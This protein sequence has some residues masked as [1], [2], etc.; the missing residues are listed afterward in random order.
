MSG[1]PTTSVEL[2]AAGQVVVVKRRCDA[3]GEDTRREAQ[4]LEA[5]RHPGVV[6]LA[7]SV[8][9]SGKPAVVTRWVGPH[10]LT[11]IGAMPLSQA[12]AIMAALADSVADLHD[13][14]VVHGS[15]TS[16]HVLVSADGRPVL[17]GFGRAHLLS[18]E[19]EAASG[20]GGTPTAEDD[21]AA[22]GDLLRELVGEE[23]DLEPIPDRRGWRRRP[24][25]HGYQRRALLTLADQAS[26]D[27]RRLRPTARALAAA[28]HE[29]IPEA[30][31]GPVQGAPEIPTGVL[32]AG[33]SAYA[34]PGVSPSAVAPA[35]ES[36]AAGSRH[37]GVK[38]P[39]PLSIFDHPEA[40]P[41]PLVAPEG[42]EAAPPLTEGRSVR[43][44]PLLPNGLPRPGNAQSRARAVPVMA[45]LVGVA[46]LLFGINELLSPPGRRTA[47]RSPTTRG[48]A[49]SPA[50]LRARIAPPGSSPRPPRPRPVRTS[51]H[52]RPSHPC[53]PVPPSS[54]D[55]DGDGCP[56]PVRVSGTLVQVR[57]TRYGVGRPGDRVLVG[58]WDC[59]RQATPAV[60]RPA[61]GEV[62]VFPR[63]AERGAPITVRP[64]A[65]IG[66]A[67]GIE[68]T[69]PDGNGC[70]QLRVRT[71]GGRVVL[72]STAPGV[73]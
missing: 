8:D 50:P 30:R 61:T 33:T 64:T 14:G 60:L 40:G 12:A 46:L 44:G 53:R 4:I 20:D 31:L 26:H 38:R 5:A 37:D 58:D 10:T 24:R 69:R 7:A 36:R 70:S 52:A 55:L 66:H 67:A 17:C 47:T 72:V 51:L 11:A 56:D 23:V 54:L 16:E 59:D 39:H 63:W 71:T 29:T 3:A 35:A 43:I 13:L 18:S 41:S 49:P 15:I 42:A 73:P 68:A 32:S 1:P 25:W 22:L 34:G 6:D 27:E 62:F 19:L 48:P 21:V 65:R 28:I 45:A 2:D 57:D 9:S